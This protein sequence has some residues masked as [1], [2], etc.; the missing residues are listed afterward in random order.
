MR[1]ET[2]LTCID[3]MYGSAGSQAGWGTD[4]Q[5]SSSASS[6]TTQ[7]SSFAH[8]GTTHNE[9][10]CGKR[11]VGVLAL[12]ETAMQAVLHGLESNSLVACR[13]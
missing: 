13:T 5:W 4:Q 3:C 7:W 11:R 2:E 6:G 12:R 10:M 8:S 9:G 1:N